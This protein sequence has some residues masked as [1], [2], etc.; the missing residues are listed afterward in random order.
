MIQKINDY[1]NTGKKNH[2]FAL[3]A[4]FALLLRMLISLKGFNWD[5]GSWEIVS[6]VT[7]K[8]QNIYA[9]TERYNYG[10]VWCY[11]LAGLKALGFGFRYFISFFLSIVDL[12]IA[13]LLFSRQRYSVAIL[14]LFSPVAIIITGF[15]NQFDNLAILLIL[16][17]VYYA[18]KKTKNGVGQG[19]TINETLV[20]SLF[21]GLSLITKH[22]FIFYPIWLFFRTK[23]LKQRLIL[24]TV[25]AALF[26][27]SFIPYLPAG[28]KPIMQNVF[29][30]SSKNNAPLYYAF[31]NRIADMI[32]TPLHISTDLL[33]KFLFFAVMILCGFFFRKKSLFD[34]FL[35]Y[36]ISIVLFSSAVACQYL[37]IPVLFTAVYPN[38]FSILYNF[39][40]FLYFTI[41]F[42][43]LDLGIDLTGFA[44]Q[45]VEEINFKNTYILVALILF[46]NL[47][48]VVYGKKIK[49]ILIKK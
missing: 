2:V 14:F 39:V 22:I 41:S 18:E 21:I 35:F 38:F 5:M 15:H 31:F 27:V 9:S 33:P 47:I 20:F 42:E 16:A 13:Y 12:L 30:Y 1:F 10:P 45:I 40:V 7:L 4:L 19:L 17:G 44:R 24:L 3:L 6:D 8:G 34:N 26:I 23:E 29:L 48:Y 49:Q 36:L 25:P 28:F 11:I 43:E 37:A 32:F 46:Y